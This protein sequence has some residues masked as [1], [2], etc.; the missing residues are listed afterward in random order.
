MNSTGQDNTDRRSDFDLKA[1]YE[2][3]TNETEALQQRCRELNHENDAIKKDIKAGALIR[4][5]LRLS[6]IGSTPYYHNR[7]RGQSSRG[8]ANR[9][10][11][12]S[13][14]RPS[15]T[16]RS[17]SPNS[18]RVGGNSN[19]AF[20]WR[21]RTPPTETNQGERPRPITNADEGRAIPVGSS[22][23]P[24]VQGNILPPPAG[25]ITDPKAS[26]ITPNIVGLIC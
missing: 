23:S 18:K 3:L 10:R 6:N 9:G 17:W 7:G 19:A 25:I 13:Q 2:Q 24:N 14:R 5:D 15:Q 12:V 4:P 16:H 21:P 22:S 8:P 26:C 11:L 1:S 20:Q